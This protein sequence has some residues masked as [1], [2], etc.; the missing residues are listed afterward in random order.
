MSPESAERASPLKRKEVYTTEEKFLINRE[1]NSLHSLNGF[2]F[3]P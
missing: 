3:I 1:L 2:V